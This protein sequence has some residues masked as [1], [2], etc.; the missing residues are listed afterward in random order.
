V[1]RLQGFYGRRHGQARRS[2]RTAPTRVRRCWPGFRRRG[3]RYR[4][5]TAWGKSTAEAGSACGRGRYGYP[6]WTRRQAGSPECPAHGPSGTAVPAR[7][8][9]KEERFLFSGEISCF[10][11]SIDISQPLGTFL[12]WSL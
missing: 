9:R 11:W 7:H 10:S 5:A 8:R 4:Q 2:W 12:S 6:L 3:D 1:E